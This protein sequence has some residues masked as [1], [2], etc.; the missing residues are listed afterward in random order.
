MSSGVSDVPEDAPES[1]F[2]MCH[3]VSLASQTLSLGR[4]SGQTQ[5]KLRLKLFCSQGSFVQIDA[6]K[7]VADVR[8]Y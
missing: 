1:E 2:D 5:T 7:I 3:C 8:S 4:E 6:M